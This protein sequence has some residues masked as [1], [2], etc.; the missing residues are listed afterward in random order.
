M[1]K[2]SKVVKVR[3]NQVSEDIQNEIA[4]YVQKFVVTPVRLSYAYI[5]DS[6]SKKILKA[7]KVSEENRPNYTNEAQVLLVVN[8]TMWDL[9]N[10]KDNEA[11]EILIREALQGISINE[12]DVVSVKKPS[13]NSSRSIMDKYTVDSVVKAKELEELVF[14]QAKDKEKDLENSQQI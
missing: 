5:A 9:L 10:A 7:K 11:T 12:K 1:S 6:K 8:E 4:D 3:F 2:E 13:F 14:A